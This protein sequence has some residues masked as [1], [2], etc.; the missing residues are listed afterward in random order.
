MTQ[1]CDIVHTGGN[2]LLLQ[3]RSNISQVDHDIHIYIPFEMFTDNRD[4][5]NRVF[6]TNLFCA[7]ANIP[8]SQGQ[9]SW[10]EINRVV[11]K[12]HKHVCVH[13]SYS[14]INVFLQINKLW[15]PEIMKYLERQV[16]SLNK[17]YS[18]LSQSLLKT[19]HYVLSVGHSTALSLL[20]IRI[21][22]KCE[23]VT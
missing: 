14:D 20:I 12:V 6:R 15:S 21:L 16:E 13:A 18:H 11:Y 22:V 7:T 17:C 4:T 19:F 8:E 10:S 5:I 9:C 3:N 2:H 23:C 1:H